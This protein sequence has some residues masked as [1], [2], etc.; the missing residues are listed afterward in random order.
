MITCYFV[1]EALPA[2]SSI[3]CLPLLCARLPRA[4]RVNSC[5]AGR[6]RRKIRAPVAGYPRA[7]RLVPALVAVVAARPAAAWSPLSWTRI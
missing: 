3:C 7:R 4:W 5:L 1:R 6:S 2:G